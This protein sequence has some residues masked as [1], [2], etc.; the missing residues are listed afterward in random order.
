MRA[1]HE[2]IEGRALRDVT[3]RRGRAMSAQE[4]LARGFMVSTVTARMAAIQA[5]AKQ[6]LARVVRDHQGGERPV[7]GA[8]NWADLH[9]REIEFVVGQDGVAR[10][11]VIIEEAESHNPVLQSRVRQYLQDAGYADVEVVTAW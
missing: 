11:R 7:V 3:D 2:G 8:I 1:R 6:V 5:A 10:Y 4:S 9:C